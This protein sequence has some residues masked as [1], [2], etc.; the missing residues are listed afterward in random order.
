ME[1]LFFPITNEED[2]VYVEEL[3]SE[4][5]YSHWKEKGFTPGIPYQAGGL[6]GDVTLIEWGK[7]HNWEEGELQIDPIQLEMARYLNSKV[8]QL[9]FRKHYSPL[10]AK[11]ITSEEHLFAEMEEAKLPVVLKSEYGL[12]GRN[13]IIFKTPSDSWKLSQVQKRLFG[14]P[15]VCED[16]V[17]ETRYFDFSTLWDVKE[18]EFFY[19]TS[20]SMWIDPDGGFRGI[21]IGGGENEYEPIFLPLVYDLVKNLNNLIPKEYSGPCAIDGFLFRENGIT[22]VQPVSEFNFRYSIGRILW[23]VRKK[24]KTKL[25]SVS[26]LLVLPY[27]KQGKLDEWETIQKLEKEL[28]GELILLTPVR[29]LSGKAYQN[30]VLYFE[31]TVENET[32]VVETIWSTWVETT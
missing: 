2:Y 15:V 30:A 5:L 25:Q 32:T 23:E 10:P 24:R 13:H 29:D 26:G 7:R 9:D 11:V 19:L 4:T 27:P 20:T 8:T 31:T 1:K 21:R 12:A 17:G 28:N 22:Q 18:G 3:P 6:L 16:W 14:F